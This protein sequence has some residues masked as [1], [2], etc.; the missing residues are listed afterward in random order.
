MLF[1]RCAVIWIV[2]PLGP[3]VSAAQQSQDN[4]SRDGN[5]SL[6]GIARCAAA[7]GESTGRDSTDRLPRSEPR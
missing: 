2:I 3:L 5:L 6:A 4:C 7:A 1:L